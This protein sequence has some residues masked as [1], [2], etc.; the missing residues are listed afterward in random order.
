MIRE[1]GVGMTL[2]GKINAAV[3]A[4]LLLMA[5][6]LMV[7]GNMLQQ[8]IE[9]RFAESEIRSTS[10]LWRKILDAQYQ[11]MEGASKFITRDR[12]TTAS[13]KER[14]AEEIEDNASSSY[15]LLSTQGVIDSLEFYDVK[16]SLLFTS[17]E[18]PLFHEASGVVLE[19][20]RRGKIAKGIQIGLAGRPEIVL[21]FPLFSRGKVLAVGVFRK[22]LQAA[23]E[24]LKHHAEAEVEVFSVSGDF[25]YSTDEVLFKKLGLGRS[26]VSGPGGR[27]YVYVDDAVFRIV[28]LPLHGAGGGR[29]GTLLTSLDETEPLRSQETLQSLSYFA[30]FTILLLA[31]GG[32]TLFLRRAFRPIEEVVQRLQRIAEGDLTATV[33]SSISRD[34][35]G[36]LTHALGSMNDTMSSVVHKVLQGAAEVTGVATEIANG[37]AALAQRTEEQSV[38]LERT[39]SN[40]HEIAD[41]VAENAAK[42]S[43]ADQASKEMLSLASG[44][45]DSIRRTID[46][47][48]N[49][50]QSS[51]EIEEIINL[52]DEIAFQTNLLALNAAVEAARAGDQGRGFA[53]VASE[54][55]NL[56]GRS[57]SAARDIKELINASISHVDIGTRMVEASGDT[58]REIMVAADEVSRA[59]EEIAA[60]SKQQAVAV[61]EVNLAIT[62]I[63]STTQDNASL[64]EQTA[65]ASKVMVEQAEA[66]RQVVAFFRVRSVGGDGLFVQAP[67]TRGTA[68]HCSGKAGEQEHYDDADLRQMAEVK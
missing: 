7:L 42:V 59:V 41:S 32:M 49:I 54:V 34:E 65:M 6:S 21:A 2:K 50:K 19:A 26:P 47:V 18:R 61:T 15:N 17:D 8:S 9:E 60:S 37:N 5:V 51:S 44:G 35:T 46:A 43:L 66:L 67:S 10:V 30:T 52:I 24:D 4:V 39:A 16:G 38:S 62:E 3:V 55:R 13:I 56:A 53:V 11:N 12:D 33:E 27:D 48:Q 22:G 29:V 23:V 45:V 36:Q 58:L 20:L 25:S 64:V 31:I 28:T 1:M 14:D 57:A 40:M 63:D 68:G